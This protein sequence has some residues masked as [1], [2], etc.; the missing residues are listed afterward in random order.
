MK[1]GNQDIAKKSIADDINNLPH[2]LNNKISVCKKHVK[3][4]SISNLVRIRYQL[5]V[6]TS[7]SRNID[8]ASPIEVVSKMRLKVK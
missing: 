2:S 8:T 4:F 5:K 3:S 1:Q 6:L 7:K